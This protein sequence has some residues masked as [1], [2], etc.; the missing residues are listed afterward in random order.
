MKRV[1][2]FIDYFE[3]GYRAGG[4]I[5][6]LK[7]YIQMFYSQYD[8][9]VVTRN[10]DLNNYIQYDY[11]TNEWL[12]KDNYRILYLNKSLIINIYRNIFNEIRPDIVYLNSFFSYKYSILP[13]YFLSKLNVNFLL[14]PRG[15]LSTSAI[16]NKWV[17]KNI[18]VF[19]AKRLGYHIIYL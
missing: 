7:N 4:P 12:V 1:L 9:Y 13:I 5:H 15:E 18:Y 11:P 19:I 8:F 17:V 10:H 3:P 14:A 16:K 2:V 6:S